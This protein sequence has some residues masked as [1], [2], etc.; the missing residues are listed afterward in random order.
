M[1]AGPSGSTASR[2]LPGDLPGDGAV[3]DD[4]GGAAAGVQ[5]AQGGAWP[6]C[7]WGGRGMPSFFNPSARGTTNVRLPRGKTEPTRDR[8][9]PGSV[10]RGL[11]DSP[12]SA[13]HGVVSL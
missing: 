10:S 3:P 13:T 9:V 8:I 12:A 1:S 5:P 11:G 7:G 6:Q 2:G 4:G